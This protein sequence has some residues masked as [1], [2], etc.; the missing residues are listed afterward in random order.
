[1]YLFARENRFRFCPG[2]L[3]DGCLAAEVTAALR[4]ATA[5]ATGPP[6]AGKKG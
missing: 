6:A 5:V 4:P 3:G 2:P 1:M